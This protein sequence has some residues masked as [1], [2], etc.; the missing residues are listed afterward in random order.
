M[1]EKIAEICTKASFVSRA[2][3]P[4]D[5]GLAGAGRTPE[6]QA[7]ERAG[8]HQPRQR[9]IWPEKVILAGDL[10]EALRPQPI[11]ERTRGLVLEASGCEKI[12]HRFN[13]GSELPEMKGKGGNPGE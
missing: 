3:E 12:R 10:V 11:G 6:D 13:L 2:N 7:A 5:R 8:T 4:R 1:P 9:P